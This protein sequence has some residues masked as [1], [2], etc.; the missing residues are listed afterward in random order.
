VSFF[1]CQAHFA[2]HHVESL[3]GTP[4]PGGHS[5]FPQSQIVPAAQQNAQLAAVAG[6]NHWL[7]SRVAMSRANVTGTP[8]L[9]QELLH[10]PH[11]DPESMCNIRPA[12]FFV[13]I[14]GQDSFPKIQ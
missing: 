6:H 4:Q 14:G 8:T 2:Q 13:I 5:Q 9:L 11:R 10:H 7:A 1:I 12:A 3:Q